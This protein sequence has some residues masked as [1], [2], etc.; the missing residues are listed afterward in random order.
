MQEGHVTAGKLLVSGRDAPK[1]LDAREESLGEIAIFVQ[2]RV[3]VPE[4]FA[5]GQRM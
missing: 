1:L 4:H 3:V 5:V 2:I